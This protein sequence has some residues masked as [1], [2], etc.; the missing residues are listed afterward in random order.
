MLLNLYAS[1]LVMLNL[2]L[3]IGLTSSLSLLISPTSSYRTLVE[4]SVKLLASKGV[5]MASPDLTLPS[6]LIS[7]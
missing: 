5:A 3:L 7:D 4:T 6:Y 2:D 1:Q